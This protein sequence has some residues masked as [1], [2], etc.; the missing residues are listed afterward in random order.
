MVLIPDIHNGFG[1]PRDPNCGTSQE[2]VQAVL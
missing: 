1:Y 2:Y